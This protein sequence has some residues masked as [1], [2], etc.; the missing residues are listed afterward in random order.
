MFLRFDDDG[1][2][3]GPTLLGVAAAFTLLIG[4][5]VTPMCFE[6]VEKGTVRVGY[7]FGQHTEII[8][9]GFHFP[10]SPLVSW[11]EI[12]TKQ[13]SEAL[14]KVDLP[15]RDQLTSHVDV[16][17]QYRA[18]GTAGHTIIN[19]TGSLEQVVQVHMIPKVREL[20]R[21]AGRTVNKAEALYTD[22]EVSRISDEVTSALRDFMTPK[23]VAVEAVLF[24]NIELPPFIVAAI[25]SKKEREQQAERQKAELARFETEQ[26]QKVKTATAERD[27]EKLNAEKVKIA[28][29][30]RAYEIQKINEAVANNPAYIKLQSLEALKQMAKDPA[31]KLIIMDGSSTSPIPFLNLGE[32]GNMP[33]TGK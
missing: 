21:N 22:S 11:T 16:S 10:V 28:A 5:I 26:Q 2:F 8:N 12:D 31:S 30:A 17:I 19:E 23:G 27:A 9:P 29:D 1:N 24:R 15:S 4:L 13:K 20:I 14:P 3:R 7:K 32:S 33:G 6:T 25:Q 18:I